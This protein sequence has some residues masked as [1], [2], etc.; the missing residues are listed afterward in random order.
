MHVGQVQVILSLPENQSKNIFPSGI[1]PPCHLAYI[2]WFS[3]FN[4]HPDPHLKMY[5]VSR[6]IAADGKKLASI[7]PVSLIQQSVHLF[8]KWGWNT[9]GIALWTSD[10]VLEKCDV[11]YVNSFKDC[12][13]YYNV[14]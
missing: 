12:H 5:K 14:Y 11:F 3:C 13:M 2:E 7:D 9:E 4:L 10:N 1:L 8:Q 6:S